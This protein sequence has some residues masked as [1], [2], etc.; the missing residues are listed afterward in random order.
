[1]SFLSDVLTGK[2]RAEMRERV[3]QILS[4]GREWCQTAQKL[5]EALN[6]LTDEL[7]KGNVNPDTAKN[8]RRAASQL[9]KE[10][11]KLVRSIEAH[12]ET[13]KKI[14]TKLG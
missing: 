6:A 5:T 14:M 2:L 4:C 11:G 9:A 7:K 12:T 8:V 3:D 13:L 10:T 1:M